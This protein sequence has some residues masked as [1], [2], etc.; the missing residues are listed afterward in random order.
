MIIKERLLNNN[1]IEK[2][3]LVAFHWNA[4]RACY[5]V[6]KMNS[7]KTVGRV[8]GYTDT[9]VMENVYF[10]FQESK[11]NYTI[12]TGKKER[13][14]FIVGEFVSFE[15]G[16]EKYDSDLYYNPKILKKFIDAPS[17]FNE[18]KMIEFDSLIKVC[19]SSTT[20]NEKKVPFIEYKN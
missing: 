3:T 5:S 4:H 12:E 13:H 9:I 20:R 6:I 14:S 7:K 15:K 1:D 8:I 18:N 19:A 16:E 17:Y 2:G 11:R 10:V